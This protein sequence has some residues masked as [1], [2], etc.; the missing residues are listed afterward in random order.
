[1][2]WGLATIWR[3]AVAESS[4][5]YHATTASL[6]M[7]FFAGTVVAATTIWFTLRKQA[8][9]PARLLL[10]EGGEQHDFE[11]KARPGPSSKRHNSAIWLAF[12]AGLG[13]V[14]VAGWG[15]FSHSGDSA[16]MFFGAG[17]LLLI[18]GLAAFAAWLKSLAGQPPARRLTLTGLGVRTC[19]RRRKRSLAT[20]ALLACGC[21]V[22]VA[23]GIFRLDANRDAVQKSSGTGGFSLM[24]NSTMPVIQ[25][26][27]TRTGREFFGLSE[28]ELSGVK[29]VALRVHDGDEASCLNLNR[30]RQPRLLGVKPELLAG[31]FTFAAVA[32]GLDPR[33]GWNLLATRAMASRETEEI[34]AIGDANSIEWALGKK[35]GDALDYVDEH[36]RPFKVRLVAA[37]A[38]SI[39]QGSL[40]IDE[41]EFTRHFP[42]ESGHRLFLLDTPGNSAAQ[43]SAALSRALQDVGLE[44]TP[45]AQR[46]NE[47]NAVQNT[48]L[49]TFQILGGLG[50]LL[51]STGL[52]VVVLRNVLE[53]RGQLGLF[54][55]VGFRKRSLHRMILIE[56]GALLAIGLGIGILAAVLSV[57]PAIIAPG[58]QI[59]YLSLAITL[60]LVLLNGTIWTWLATKF[61]LRGDL[62]AALRNE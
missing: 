41:G 44:L 14:L 56:H 32:K 59:P 8:R 22:I 37:V 11:L 23:I 18:A 50:L 33:E 53:R 2:L 57:L 40:I 20:S 3:R 48:Y 52:G 6:L 35:L 36:G 61:A 12:T 28:P 26:L 38:N 60:V 17:A 27:N 58:R 42:G 10:A 7:G 31:R 45:A 49:G 16:G 46:L 47:F 30:S 55:A 21:F 29:V 13:A 15:A 4:L 62:L 34:P 54:L 24:G 43:V 51:G 39:L 1:M 9:Q 25:D 5:Q 19:A